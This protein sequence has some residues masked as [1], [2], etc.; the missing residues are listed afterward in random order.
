[1]SP[2][3]TDYR[4]IS[5]DYHDLLESF[6]ITRESVQISFRDAEGVLQHRSA[7]ITDVFAR[8]GS[9]YLV[10][11]T[12]EAVRLDRLLT[13]NDFKLAVH[14]STDTECLWPRCY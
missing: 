13:V 4:P 14:G 7:V 8:D 12:G 2:Q 6:A 10:V 1:M 5:C 9:E 3:P 11:S